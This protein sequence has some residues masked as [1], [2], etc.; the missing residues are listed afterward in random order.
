MRFFKSLLMAAAVLAG[1][2]AHSAGLRDIYEMALQ[3]DPQLRAAEAAFRASQE[4]QTLGRSQLLP[5]I[6]IGAEYSET[7]MDLDFLTVLSEDLQVDPT[8]GSARS[9]TT[10]YSLSI[11]QPLFDLPRWFEFRQGQALSEQG[12]AEFAADQQE[13]ILRVAD[14]YFNVLRA[15]ENLETATAEEKAIERQLEQTRQR[16]EVGLLPITDVHE[17]QA[18][19][20]NATV[21]TLEARS[22]LDI[23]F[24]ALQVLTGRPITDIYGLATDAPIQNPE[25]LD[26]EEWVR[27]AVNNNFTLRSAQL[28]RDAAEQFAAARRSEHLPKL[29]ASLGY[30]DVDTDGRR[31]GNS[32]YDKQDGHTVA[33]HATMP[34]FTGGAVSAQRRQANEQ[35]IELEELLEL[36]TRN[37]VQQARTL[38]LQ[39]V[40]DVARVDARAQAITSASSALEA[41]QA[42][43]EVGTRNIVDV[44]V[45]QR[46]LF[47][48]KR[49]Y[50]NAR[51]D[52]ISSRLRLREVAGQLS[53]QDVM[54]LESFLDQSLE[55]SQYGGQ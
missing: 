53:P 31:F 50:A 21:N 27:F 1:V 55:V 38:H 19:Y 9:D 15:H 17:A 47:Q 11:T 43:Y 26:R 32:F 30:R 3:N 23:A 28:A 54:A 41:T 6:G 52:Y 42:G 39:V 16:Y 2:Q 44:L 34:I 46:T 13:V 4:L 8:Q 51:Y 5:Q 10:T 40:T 20:D 35:Y 29:S 12:K 25:P 36:A 24:E 7:D 49:D 48:A 18:A 37:T 22:A 33:L 14:A 45:A